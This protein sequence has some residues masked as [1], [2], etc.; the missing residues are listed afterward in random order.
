MYLKNDRPYD[1]ANDYLCKMA[2]PLSSLTHKIRKQ[3]QQEKHP[4][5]I[6][7][8][9]TITILIGIFKSNLSKAYIDKS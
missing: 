3:Q 4:W 1:Y 7:F 6:T 5:N 8:M 2:D 9:I